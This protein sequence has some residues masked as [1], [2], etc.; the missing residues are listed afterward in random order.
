MA[1]LDRRGQGRHVCVGSDALFTTTAFSVASTTKNDPLLFGWNFAGVDQRPAS[2]SRINTVAA[3]IGCTTAAGDLLPPCSRC[4]EP[5]NRRFPFS[6]SALAC[7][8]I[9]PSCGAR[10][11]RKNHHGVT[12]SNG[13]GKAIR[14]FV[15]LN[16]KEESEFEF[17]VRLPLCS[18]RALRDSVVRPGI[19][20][21][22][23]VMIH[24]RPSDD[25]RERFIFRR[26]D[27]CVAQSGNDVRA[28]QAS[29]P[30]HSIHPR[31][32]E[33]RLVLVFSIFIR[34]ADR[35]HPF[36]LRNS[37]CAIPSSRRSSPQRGGVGN[38]NVIFPATPVQSA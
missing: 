9:R 31:E 25:E 8:C 13:G 16:S 24:D 28:T 17:N 20:N 34:V 10:S 4:W 18:L 14:F 33:P 1:G 30:N 5:G 37:S 12:E 19:S 3:P 29:P 38:F 35:T 2:S 21:D 36:P 15:C 6:K 27:A 11:Q 32:R 22:T 26:G 23:D 7:W